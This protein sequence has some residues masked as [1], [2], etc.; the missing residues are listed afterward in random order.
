MTLALDFCFLFSVFFFLVERKK[1][2]FPTVNY[3]LALDSDILTK[4]ME[5]VASVKHTKKY[6]NNQI[7]SNQIKSNQMRSSKTPKS[8]KEKKKIKRWGRVGWK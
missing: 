8:E 5:H 3:P 1:F 4:C 6:I 2:V 7:S